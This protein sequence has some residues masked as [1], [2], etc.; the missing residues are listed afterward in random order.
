M[1]VETPKK[2]AKLTPN[3]RAKIISEYNAGKEISNPDYYVVENKNGVLNVRRK[4]EKVPKE[5]KTEKKAKPE[6][7]KYLTLKQDDCSFKIPIKQVNFNEGFLTIEQ[8]NTMF[9]IPAEEVK[10][11]KRKVVEEKLTDAVIPSPNKVDKAASSSSSSDEES[12]SKPKAL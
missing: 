12:D 11:R 3:E 7:Q 10:K 1:S 5:E 6:K 9:K 4:K 8:D 2:V